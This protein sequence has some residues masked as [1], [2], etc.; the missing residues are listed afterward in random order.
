[1]GDGF[2]NAVEPASWLASNGF[3]IDMNNT[4]PI[5]STFMLVVINI[6]F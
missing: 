4:P 1:M 3:N 6:Y 2:C 5:F